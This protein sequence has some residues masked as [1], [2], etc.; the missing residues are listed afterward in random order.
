[1]HLLPRNGKKIIEEDL[2][3]LGLR[4]RILLVFIK[5]GTKNRG[6]V[7]QSN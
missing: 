6:M 4:S 7:F 3:V 5:V 2:G 1:M